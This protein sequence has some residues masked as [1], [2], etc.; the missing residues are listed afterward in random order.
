MKDV[1]SDLSLSH[2]DIYKIF[3]EHSVDGLMVIDSEGIVRFANAAARAL[4]ADKTSE[5]VGFWLGIPAIQAPTELVIPGDGKFRYVELVAAS[6]NWKG[7]S[8]SLASLHEV[9]ERKNAENAVRESAAE[10]RTLAE[11]MP[12]IVWITRPDGWNI[13]FNQHWMDYTG[14][15]LEE[16][17]GHGWN[18]PFHPDDQQR[19][20]DAWQK[21]TATNGIYSIECRMRG[22]DGAYRWWLVRGVPL[23]DADGGILKW[24][25]TCTDIHDL[26]MAGLEIARAIGEL[27]ESERRFSDLLGNVELVSMMLDREAR[28]TYCND[29][30]LRLTGWQ[31]EEVI[32]K[33]WWELF[34]PPELSNLEGHFFSALLANQPEAL[35]HENE[36]VTRAGEHR[37]IRWSNSVLRSVTGEVIGTA[38]IGEDITERRRAE[39]ATRQLTE[40][41]MTTLESITDAF[42]TVDREWRFTFLNREAERLLARTREEL[43]GSNLWTAF[44]ATIGSAFE[45]E[46]RRAV[47]NE[48][49]VDFEE[50]YP[51][52][53]TWFGVR[54]YPSE[55][56]LAVYFRDITEHKKTE[57]RIVQLN[58]VHL[59]LSSI[60][61]LIVRVDDR[62]DLFR[63][64]C[65]IAVDAGGFRMAMLVIVD[66]VTML[67]VS[68]TSGGKNEELLAEIKDVLSSSESMQKTLVGQ[69]IRENKAVI[70]NDT[71]NDPRLLFGKLYT[72]AGVKS[73]VVLPLIMSGKTSG[74]LALYASEINFF[75]QDEMN[76]LT[77][78][79]S[80]IAYAIDQIAKQ[81]RLNYLAYYDVLTGL[82][83]RSLFLER[84]AQYMHSADSRGHKLAIGLIDLERFKSINDSLGRPA[85]D[86]VLKQMAEW[87]SRKAGDAR[88]LTRVDADH[89]AFVI[90]AIK[91]EGNLTGLFDKLAQTFLAHSFPVDNADLRLAYKAGI[92]IFPDDGTDAETVYRNAESALK[93]AKQSGDRYLFHTKKMT[94]AVATKLTLENQLRQALDN[95]EFV[96]HYQPKV[97]LASGKMTSAEALIRWNDPRTGLVPPGEFIPVLEETGLIF[98]VGRWALR[99]AIADYL[100]WRA[101][102]LDTVRIAVNVSPLQLRNR[103]FVDE[104]RQ[105]IGIDAHAA[106]ALELEITESLI[107]ED[108]KGNITSLT[109][110]RD[111][112]VSIAIDDFGTGFSS[113]SYLAKLPVHTLK[114]D[115]TFVMDM[116]AGAEGLALISTIINLAHALK[117][118]VVAEGVETEEQ[119]RLLRL[120]SCDE[121]QGFLFSKPVPAEIFET[122]FL[123]ERTR[124]LSRHS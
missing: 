77:G 24:F 37:L 50:F 69:V 36:I 116:T 97:N 98:D 115:R 95:E 58:R 124:R 113:L 57:D 11:A 82:A 84:V 96:L 75:Q 109:A 103:G 39:E 9:T 81:E 17:L 100:R 20:W 33:N 62:D 12:Q 111:L 93:T 8:A 45:R 6:I 72:E 4:F 23:L 101:A 73:M 34:V 61:A 83:N 94:A 25:G 89:F 88:L 42:F 55:Q 68:I 123:A 71:E 107:M 86:S 67:P 90:P 121:M 31:R 44:P 41:L 78:L 14:L 49:S 35:H 15:T 16:S 66:P 43:T 65:T 47:E 53:N 51:P 80:D 29:Y 10:F 28:I 27:R 74:V 64:A 122:R 54:A 117:L 22:A 1:S 119:S 87:L 21:A 91:A 114:I 3:V 40:R 92:A 30:L 70:S 63:G 112:G 13:Y 5:L 60:N 46:Y 118:K 7:K 120:I 38:S 102:G 106:E 104:V 76:L 105:V 26:K 52:L 19:A 110:I 99:Q 18:K 56:G 79:A 32:G 2:D 48:K 85:G 59:V 108:V